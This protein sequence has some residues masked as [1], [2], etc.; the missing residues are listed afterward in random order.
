MEIKHEQWM[1]DQSKVKIMIDGK[2]N[3]FMYEGDANG[4]KEFSQQIRGAECNKF[5]AS[6]G[7]SYKS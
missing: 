5:S 2:N 6:H 4:L 3:Y 1:K 7:L